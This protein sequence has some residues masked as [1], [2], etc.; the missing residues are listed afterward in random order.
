MLNAKPL[1]VFML[2]VLLTACATSNRPQG[3]GSHVKDSVRDRAKAHTDL[4]AAYLQKNKLVIALDEFSQAA[5]IMPSYALAYTGLALVRSA[6]GQDEEAEYNFKKSIELGPSISENYNNYGTFLCSR[7]RYDES[8]VQFL[9]AVK[10]PLYNAPNVAYSNAGICA[11]RKKDYKTAVVY[12]NKALEI[13]PLT[14]DAAHRLA[15]IQLARGD[16]VL[17]KKTLQNAIVATPNAEVLWLGVRIARALGDKNNEASYS[18]E[19]RR[20]F[21]NSK[22]TQLLF[23]QT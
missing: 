10:N 6:L 16:V 12:L 17:A 1:F 18:L 8:I 20:R 11:A 3:V 21:P 2:I 15:E 13:Q 4:G 5:Q 7:E 14:H 23:N 22:E 19:L 9:E